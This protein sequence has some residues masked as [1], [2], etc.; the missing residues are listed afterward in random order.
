MICK[1]IIKKL[2]FTYFIFLST[3]FLHLF[4]KKTVL[5]NL[6]GKD[7]LYY[8]FPMV[9]VTISLIIMYF[10]QLIIIS[11]SKKYRLIYYLPLH[12][13]TYNIPNYP[14]YLGV[15]QISGFFSN[16]I[17]FFC[18]FVY[19]MYKAIFFSILFILLSGF[20]SLT[21]GPR[22]IGLFK[23]C[24]CIFFFIDVILEFIFLILILSASNKN[25]FLAYAKEIKNI[26][27]IFILL[28]LSIKAYFK[29]YKPF[30]NNILLIREN[31]ISEEVHAFKLKR[32]KQYIIYTLIYSI[33][34]IIYSL[35]IFDFSF[36]YLKKINSFYLEKYFSGLNY[37]FESIFLL[38]FLIMTFPR[39]YP[40]GYL[41]EINFI[42]DYN[43]SYHCDIK[44]NINLENVD[45]NILLEYENKKYPFSILNPYSNNDFYFDDLHIGYVQ[46]DI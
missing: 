42:E 5:L 44:N 4:S 36:H 7:E 37:F 34:R 6:K 15:L 27:E 22:I 3:S 31:I 19:S 9:L 12:F 43:N 30:K 35:L 40:E 25:Y 16:I 33:F 45:T 14:F 39:P 46:N 20:M 38:I 24:Y 13:L 29:V 17:P 41:S 10:I 21:F 32:L 28:F 23:V 18:S 1:E 26:L 11:C 2:I 8:I